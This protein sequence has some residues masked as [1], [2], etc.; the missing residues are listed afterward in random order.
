MRTC[1]IVNTRDNL[2]LEAC[3]YA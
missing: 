3:E 1:K 2:L